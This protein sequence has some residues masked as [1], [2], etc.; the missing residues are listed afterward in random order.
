VVARERPYFAPQ[1]NLTGYVLP[2]TGHNIALE[3]NSTQA[4]QAMLDWADS[5]LSR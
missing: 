5:V 1:A 3:L 4:N 2:D